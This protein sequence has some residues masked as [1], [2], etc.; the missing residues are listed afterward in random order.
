[1]SGFFVITTPPDCEEHKKIDESL[2]KQMRE[3]GFI[4]LKSLRQLHIATRGEYRKTVKK[5]TSKPDPSKIDKRREYYERPDVKEK[6]KAYNE[7]QEVKERKKELQRKR[8]KL[9]TQLR[10]KEPEV[11]AKLYAQMELDEKEGTTENK[12]NGFELPGPKDSP[13]SE[14]ET[15]TTVDN[16]VN[17]DN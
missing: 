3:A 11:Y 12:P 5:V 14:E 10:L 15:T 2:I 4:D 9:L 1:M 16:S 6:R 17:K 13:K 7:K 8:S